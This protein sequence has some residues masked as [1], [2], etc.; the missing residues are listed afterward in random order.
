MTTPLADT[1]RSRPVRKPYELKDDPDG[2]SWRARE[3]L[4]DIFERE[5]LGPADG[6]H[7][8]ITERPD[9]VY[10]VGRIAPTKLTRTWADT[11]DTKAEDLPP[12]VDMT[13]EAAETGGITV[14]D[15]D[16]D[17]SETEDDDPDDRPQRRGLMIPTSMGLR[18][19][20][21]LDLDEFTITACWGQYGAHKE[22]TEE[23]EQQKDKARR[24]RRLFK[25]E[26]FRIPVVIKSTDLPLGHVHEERVRDTVV[27]RIDRFD[28]TEHGRAIIQVALCNDRETPLVIPLDAWLFQTR[29]EVDA[30][31][32]AVF[33]PVR[34]ALENDRPERDDEL[35]RLELQYRDRLEFAQGRTCSVDWEQAEGTR[36]ASRLWTTWLP[37]VETPQTTAREIKDALLDMT[38]LARA[39]VNEL[40]TGLAPIID[41]YRSWL[42]EKE[43]EAAAFERTHLRADG[44][45]AVAEARK[46]LTSLETGLEYLLADA[47]ARRCFAFMN[48][49]M[50]EQRIQS[51]V[52]AR[53]VQHSEE[54]IA[55][56]REH[57]LEYEKH[58][59]HWRTFQLAF[60]LAQIPL[61]ADPTTEYRSGELAKAQLL[62]FP[63][64]GGKTEAY[65]GLAAFT[66]AARR[67]AGV[68][69][70][71]TGPLDGTGGVAVI[72]RY[73]LRLLTS[74]QFQRATA[75][76][77]AA[78]TVRLQ[79]PG[80]WG[81]EPFRIGLWVGTAVSP[82]RFDEAAEEL[83]KAMDQGGGYRLTVLQ[84]QRCPWCGTPITFKDIKSDKTERRIRVYCGDDLAE[85]PFAE[86]GDA[87]DGLPV[88]TVDEE[89]YRLAPAFVIA[90]VDKFARLAREG[91]AASLFG[92]VA[93]R[94][95]RHGY[96]HPDYRECDVSSGR[97]PAKNGH[98]AAS[99]RPVARL[100]PPDLIIQDELHL[101]TGALGTTV[102]LFEVA[103]DELATWKTPAGQRARPLLVASTATARNAPEQVRRLYGR[104]AAIFP[105]QV[106]DAGDT[107]FSKEQPIDREHPGRR[108]IGVSTA[109]VRLTSAEI[110]VSEILMAAGQ[111]LLDRGGAEADPYMTL[112]S[113]FSSTRELAGMARYMGDDI[114][115][116]LAKGRHWSRLPRRYGTAFEGLN[117]A[118]LTSRVASREITTTLDCMAIGFPPEKQGTKPFDAVLA[119]SMLQVGVDVT[120]LG[121]MLVVGQPKHT[122]EYIQASSRVGRDADRPGLVVAL[123]N[124]ARPRDLAHFETFRH[125]H[126]TFYA[127]VE[128]LSV[129]PFS[130]TA[131]ERGL[132]AV[133][134]SAARV[135]QAA[136]PDG[137]SAETGAQRIE[138]ERAFV[139]AL[140]ERL[141]ERALLAAGEQDAARVRERL[142]NRLDQWTNRLTF[143]RNQRK[144]LAYEYVRDDTVAGPLM[145]SAENAK[146]KHDK[147]DEPPFV[148][149]NSMR[150]VQPEINLLV[151]PIPE[152]LYHGESANA[153]RWELPQDAEG[154]S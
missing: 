42:E 97:H 103:V 95:D 26:D 41:G 38:A 88:L 58:P 136:R 105:P 25:R 89:I 57:V 12:D 64:G 85:C 114:Q 138:T 79:D 113:Y 52:A 132:D 69:D 29:L 66:F 77:C 44:A 45:E 154:A 153:P 86:G 43:D 50:A 6:I 111:L 73:T 94:C 117:V 93:K 92:Y 119:T 144:G 146:A 110:R 24:P 125:Y 143:V 15:V 101:I 83:G 145:M 102:G 87:V 137:L 108:Y 34:D 65:L 36:R 7:E 18:F 115:S 3:N 56:A 104:D 28:D 30:G 99:V 150:E 54:S 19:Q 78:E 10:L 14:S 63:T 20:I 62:F 130:A 22:E 37:V 17:P 120:R 140:I 106:L 27:L 80:T 123:C 81:D 116:A 32:E 67:L 51:Q 100:R 134:V 142:H 90:T 60:I 35:R 76:M 148:V 5:L 8:E 4:T 112:V 61:M 13:A 121:L 139:E 74:Q 55:E 70:S 2:T 126:E 128:A 135:A 84:I 133:L 40:R 23:A 33:L 11:S 151:S 96:L 91:Q 72:M 1:D 152:R 16:N 124:W 107:F 48:E 82:K 31:G 39:D 149:P 127:Q 131:I 129:T 47:D 118:E 46:T 68:V 109:G 9:N 122:A 75:L 147:R 21:P 98:P 53:R 59:H 49:V 71:E 141:Y